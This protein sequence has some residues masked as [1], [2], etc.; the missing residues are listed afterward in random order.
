MRS[1]KDSYSVSGLTP[2]R[3]DFLNLCSKHSLITHDTGTRFIEYCIRG[4]LKQRISRKNF[5]WFISNK[6][7]EDTDEYRNSSKVKTWRLTA[8]GWRVLP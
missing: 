5:Q 2:A 4:Q 3:R 1:L 6:L 8:N 7:L